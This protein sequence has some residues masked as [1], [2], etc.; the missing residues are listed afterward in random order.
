MNDIREVALDVARH[1]MAEHREQLDARIRTSIAITSM[2]KEERR[3]ISQGEPPDLALRGWLQHSI[4]E[5]LQAERLKAKRKAA[6]EE[7]KRIKK[8]KKDGV[9]Y[10]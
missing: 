10:E 9:S 6:E 7:K 1:A 2:L 8:M 4:M 3:N 5:K